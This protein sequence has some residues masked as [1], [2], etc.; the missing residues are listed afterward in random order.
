MRNKMNRMATTLTA[1]ASIL[2]AMI[3]IIVA[4]NQL[5]PEKKDSDE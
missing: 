2:T 3:S 5:L 1:V 4:I